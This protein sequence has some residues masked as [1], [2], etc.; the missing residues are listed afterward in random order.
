MSTREE[1]YQVIRNAS[2]IMD[3]TMTLAFS[4]AFEALGD[5]MSQALE[6]LGQ[7]LAQALGGEAPAPAKRT[8]EAKDVDAKIR[9]AMEGFEIPPEQWQVMT[10]RLT[11]EHVARV[12]TSARTHLKGLPPLGGPLNK[13][14]LVGYIA[15]GLAND[16]RVGAFMREFMAMGQEVMGGGGE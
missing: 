10:T 12:T 14:Q 6:A 15:L 2:A 7:G 1:A 3:A 11:D 5:Q 13:D 4:S 16:E 8:K 9:E